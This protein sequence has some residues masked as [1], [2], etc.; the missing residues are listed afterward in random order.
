MFVT[1]RSTFLVTGFLIGCLEA[2]FI[3]GSLYYLSTWYKAEEYAVRNTAFYLG[4]LGA[5]ALSGVIASGILS[6]SGRSGLAGWQWL[7]MLEG[8]MTVG[9]GIVWLFLLP[10]TPSNCSPLLFPKWKMFNNRQIHILATRVI[11]DDAQKSA[12]ARVHITFRDVVHVFGN[13]RIWQHVLLSFIGMMPGQALG[14]FPLKHLILIFSSL[15][16]S[17]H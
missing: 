7:F 11:V 17:Y 15:L 2:G 5:S 14:T 6:L 10:E 3:P 9:I 4:N 12:G 1:G 8:V 13:W 16:S